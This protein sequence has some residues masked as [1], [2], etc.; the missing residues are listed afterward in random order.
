MAFIE[1]TG[2]EPTPQ[3]S[4]GAKLALSLAT[5]LQGSGEVKLVP[6]LSNSPG[7][8]PGPPKRSWAFSAKAHNQALAAL[9]IA[10]LV[11]A[12]MTGPSNRVP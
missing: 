5:R 1:P 9:W 6:R 10:K 4:D 11:L 2:P 3:P 7:L 8:M 12:P